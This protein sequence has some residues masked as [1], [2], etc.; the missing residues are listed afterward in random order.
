MSTNENTG[1]SVERLYRELE[2]EETRTENEAELSA[3]LVGEVSDGLSGS[4]TLDV[5]SA[6]VTESLD[7]VLLVLVGLGEEGTHGKGL[8]S[9]LE[10]VFGADLSPG[11][12]Y[13]RLHELEEEGLLEVQELV[14]TKEYRIADGE[15]VRERIEGAMRQHLALAAVFRNGLGQI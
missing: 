2:D 7:E 13:P 15:R 10:T 8:M 6:L 3:E 4:R 9:D 14:R 11:V 12:V 1:A 5:E